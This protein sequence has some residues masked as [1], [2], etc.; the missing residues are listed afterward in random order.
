MAKLWFDHGMTV[1]NDD[2]IIVQ[3]NKGAFWM[4]G[5]PWLG[6]CLGIDLSFAIT[7]RVT[8]FGGFEYH[9]ATFDAEGNLN[10]RKDLAHP[11]SFEHDADGK[12]ILLTLG[13]EYLVTGPW[14]V[15]LAFTYQKW[16]T[17]PGLDRLYYANGSVAE[18]RLNEV[19][20]DSYALM[21]GLVY[22]FGYKASTQDNGRI[23]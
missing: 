17:D 11:K 15:N 8:L 20:W 9:W 7:E 18:T 21:L 2:R 19:N 5:T 1:L 23:K 16:S 4:H 14:S 22:R 12:G 13:A 3:E 10:L 6:P